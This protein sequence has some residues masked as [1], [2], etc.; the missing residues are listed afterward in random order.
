MLTI[1]QAAEAVG[2]SDRQLRRRIEA[3]TPLLAPHCRRGE[4]NRLL[5]GHGAI[6]I[7]RAVEDHRKTGVTL[8][9]AVGLVQEQMGGT[10]ASEQER[11]GGHTDGQAVGTGDVSL[12]AELRDRIRYLEA[13][14]QRLWSLV[15][16]L[17]A[18]P[19]PRAA[20]R[21]WPFGRKTSR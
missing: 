7:L 5:L 19:A 20:R 1:E 9:D 16:D 17:K 15:D 18:L 11:A 13:Q 14:N 21:W 6:E 10:W 4:K 12:V 2:L 8:K 3:T